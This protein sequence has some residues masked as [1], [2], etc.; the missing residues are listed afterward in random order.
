MVA[1][2]ADVA[3]VGGLR[4]AVEDLWGA[5]AVL[6]TLVGGRASP[7][8]SV[9]AAAFAAIRPRLGEEMRACS[10]GRELSGLGFA[11]DV[12]VASELDTSSV[13]PSLV[14]GVFRPA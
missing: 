2:G 9:A 11:D 13:V 3:V 4:V 7:E 8:A 12:A 14:D 10:S 6:S 5:G 1:S